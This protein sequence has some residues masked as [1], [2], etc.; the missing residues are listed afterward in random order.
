MNS[1]Y[2]VWVDDCEHWLLVQI[3]GSLGEVGDGCSLEAVGEG[4]EGYMFRPII[5]FYWTKIMVN[6]QG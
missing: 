2:G 1:D 6:Y 4:G 3:C 5:F